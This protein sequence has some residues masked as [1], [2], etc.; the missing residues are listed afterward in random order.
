MSGG[1]ASPEGLQG[2]VQG[3]HRAWHQYRKLW[4]RS[5]PH[6]APEHPLDRYKWRTSGQWAPN[7]EQITE[8]P[9]LRLLSLPRFNTPPNPSGDQSDEDRARTGS[10][11]RIIPFFRSLSEPGATGSS[12]RTTLRKARSERRAT[13]VS[14]FISSLHRRISRVLEGEAETDRG[15][16]DVKGPPAH[17]FSCGQ[18]PYTDSSAWERKFCVLTDSQLILLNK[19]DEATGEVQE[20]PTGSQKGRSLRR[21]VS[22]P[23]EGQFP[24]FQA[25]GAAVLG[26]GLLWLP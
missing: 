18:S 21:T 1:G 5:D 8:P 10:L 25:E 16:S 22:V 26:K 9:L 6:Q 7:N 24:E 19:D 13:A 12:E 20:S 15:E 2:P 11:R 4:R 3:P 23:S 14:S 17:R